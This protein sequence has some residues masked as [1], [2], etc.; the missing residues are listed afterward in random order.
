ML[1]L[2]E[3][4]EVDETYINAGL[5][6]RNRR[7]GKGRKRGGTRRRGRGTYRTDRPPIFTVVGRKTR[8]TIYRME[9]RADARSVR[10]VIRSY[11]AK[12][13]TIYTDD[14]RSYRGLYGYGHR[15][16]A[17]SE[18]VYAC[19]DAHINGCE[20]RNL[21]FDIFMLP[22]RGVA[23]DHLDFYAAS[24]TVWVSL[25]VLEPCEA[26]ESIEFILF[27]YQPRKL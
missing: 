11:V 25:Y 3:D 8:T 16:V 9:K 22:R 12:G 15:S 1:R 23:K 5:K 2:D 27:G 6:G 13:N 17:H 18:G 4:C 14:Y 7:G 20:S 24:A 21:C 19:G 26:L 10:R